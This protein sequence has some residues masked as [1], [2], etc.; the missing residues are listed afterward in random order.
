MATTI[1]NVSN[2]LPVTV[3]EKITKSSGGLVAALEGVAADHYALH[4]IGWPG[5]EIPPARREHIERELVHDYGCTPVFLSREETRGFYEG[6]SNSSIWPLL[7][8]MPSYVRYE[9][10]WWDVYRD[11]NRKFADVVLSMA[12]PDDLVWVHDYQ[13]MLL[14]RMLTEAMPSLRV[15]FF[16]HT[17]F[18]SYDI[19]RRHPC[20]SELVS[21][22]LG[23]DIVGFHTYSYMQH[24]HSVALRLLGYESEITR[25]NHEGRSTLTGVY[26]IGINAQRFA[27]E[28]KTPE[29]ARRRQEFAANDQGKQI[30]LSV[31]RMDYTKGILHRLDAIELF[32]DSAADRDR[33]KFIFISVPSREGVEDYKAL[34]EEVE[35]RVGHINGRFSTLAGSPIRFYHGSV[36]FTDLCALY[37][38]SHVGL[39]TPLTD[40]MNL[41]AKEYVA[42]Q[43]DDPG[44]LVLSEFAGA[45]EE[46][47]NAVL[48]NPYDAQAVAD[49]IEQALKMPA[50]ERRARIEPMRRRVM[51]HDAR[52]WAS[53][54]INDLQS[55]RQPTEEEA[56]AGEARRLIA[57]AIASEKRIALFLDY[58]G[59]LRELERDPDAARP[60]SAIRALL[61][62][63]SHRPNIDLTIISGR[64]AEQMQA[65][66]GDCPFGLIAEH[67]ASE[68]RPG[69]AQQWEQLDRNLS[70]AW[71]D[72]V[73][74]A[75]RAYEDST[76]GTFVENKR[77]S[78]VWHYR[79]A[80]PEFGKW[81]ADTLVSELM[82]LLANEP[83][84]I[85]HGK[86]IVEVTAADVNKGAAVRRII[87]G[88]NYD[89]VVC[90][91]DDQTDESMFRLDVPGLLTI[92]VGE[93]NTQARYR[94]PTPAAFRKLL[95][96]A[97][98]GASDAGSSTRHPDPATAH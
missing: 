83:L 35:A 96:E 3:G 69:P 48:V 24:F 64:R 46:L 4:W 88:E 45:A 94:V 68:R 60:S 81:K 71:K 13:L 21:G 50:E 19:F 61:D 31:E 78:L 49:A 62:S 93:G 70:Y 33:V 92:K 73:L 58:D 44:V 53:S 52:Y 34:R 97:L 9:S 90:A 98:A 86:K 89:L 6:F 72:D 54:F 95:N 25:I 15:G 91:G 18:P 30:V 11:V 51:R 82:A 67:G 77:T 32:L 5:A 84:V 36:N 59:T 55:H 40:G 14:P 63:L 76:P 43:S 26:P 80:D 87:G 16:L 56:E 42:A 22:M 66:F 37:S 57:E 75:L 79:R 28:L 8:S 23:A 17:P 39:I 74:K 29:F 1:L 20:R 65:W 41:V 27:D 7:H 85:R 2:R 12:K 47:F 10:Q 38:S